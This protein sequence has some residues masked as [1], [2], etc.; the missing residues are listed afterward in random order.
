MLLQGTVEDAP[1]VVRCLLL[2]LLLLLL[3]PLLHATDQLQV[4]PQAYQQVNVGIGKRSAVL[5]MIC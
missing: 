3:L 1:G 5:T 2:L 4:M